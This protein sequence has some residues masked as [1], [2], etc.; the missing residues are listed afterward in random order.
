MAGAIA[1]TAGAIG[2]TAGAAQVSHQI[3]KRW[4]F[5]SRKIVNRY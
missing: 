3:P 2:S 4:K 1:A 5:L